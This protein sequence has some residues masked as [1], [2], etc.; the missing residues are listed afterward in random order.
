[1]TTDSP[2]AQMLGD[3]F[4]E[5]A[6]Y[7]KMYTQYVNNHDGNAVLMLLR[8]L[9]VAQRISSLRLF[10]C[11]GSC[12]CHIATTEAQ[13]VL[14]TVSTRPSAQLYLESLHTAGEAEKRTRLHNTCVSVTAAD[15]IRLF[16]SD[17]VN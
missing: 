10:E 7:F 2:F 12:V 5:F 15:R 13:T 14:K 17:F 9:C 16:T 3:Q 6:P 1:M 4:I 11:F 8:G